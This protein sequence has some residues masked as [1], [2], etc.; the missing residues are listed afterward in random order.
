MSETFGRDQKA[1]RA[2]WGTFLLLLSMV[3]VIWLR[4]ARKSEPPR[5][6]RSEQTQTHTADTA[7]SSMQHNRRLSGVVGSD[8]EGLPELDRRALQSVEEALRSPNSEK[9]E[10]I[11]YHCLPELLF[12]YG[13]PLVERLLTEAPSGFMRETLLR[14]CAISWPRVNPDAALTWATRLLDASECQQARERVLTATA[15]VDPEKAVRLAMKSEAAGKAGTLTEQLVG[16]WAAADFRKSCEWA[17]SLPSGEQRDRCVAH[18]A[19]VEAQSF[20]ADAARFAIK[21]LP[22]GPVL[23]ETIITT[24]YYW[25]ERN[26]PEARRWVESFPAGALR[27]RALQE[28][29][30]IVPTT[31]GTALSG[32]G[33]CQ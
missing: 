32:A 22:P 11:L 27:E 12:K 24:V 9:T 33:Q 4:S 7:R 6:A 19:A 10:S 30:D 8:F 2:S 23:D 13:A 18:V 28:V 1:A 20:P 16:L 17:L 29:N 26:R 25:A 31:D 21:R 3:A 14:V 5:L 15:G